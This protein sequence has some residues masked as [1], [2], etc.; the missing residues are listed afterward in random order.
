MEEN[1][2]GNSLLNKWW[3]SSYSNCSLVITPENSILQDAL[4]DTWEKRKEVL[5]LFVEKNYENHPRG[6]TLK[7]E[8]VK[9]LTLP[10]CTREHQKWI[11][12]HLE[13]GCK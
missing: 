13:H 2:A 7:W 8:W 5:S 4:L 1:G 10:I 11:F 3:I 12:L 6:R 9:H